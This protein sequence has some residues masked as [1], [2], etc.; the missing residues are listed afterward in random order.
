MD[1][2][3]R[4]YQ[5]AGHK[6]VESKLWT[7]RKEDGEERAGLKREAVVVEMGRSMGD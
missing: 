5:R 6:L 7:G 3:N 1:A 2:S 4:G